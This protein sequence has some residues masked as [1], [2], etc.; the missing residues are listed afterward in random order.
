MTVWYLLLMLMSLS[1][2]TRTHV[3]MCAHT[4][5]CTHIHTHTHTYI[6]T[7]MK[8]YIFMSWLYINSG[9]LIVCSMLSSNCTHKHTTGN[10]VVNNTSERSVEM[11]KRDTS[12]VLSSRVHA[13][14]PRLHCKA[15]QSNQ[16]TP[17]TT[18]DSNHEMTQAHAL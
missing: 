17:L 6:R 14:S 15:M 1:A 12:G 7:H 2:Y 3:H 16:T 4:R 18:T 5:T 10:K 9:G 11:K 13:V 8:T